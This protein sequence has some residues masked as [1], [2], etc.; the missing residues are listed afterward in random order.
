MDAYRARY[1]GSDE[2]AARSRDLRYSSDFDEEQ[3]LIHNFI[4]TLCIVHERSILDE[5]GG[6]DES[7]Q[8]YEDW[9]LWIRMSRKFKFHHIKKVSCEYS[10]RI[11]GRSLQTGT[12]SDL[13]WLL[14]I[15]YEKNKGFAKDKPHVLEQQRRRLQAERSYQKQVMRIDGL[16]LSYERG[17]YQNEGG[18]RWMSDHGVIVLSAD[19]AHVSGLI[20]FDVSCGAS[21]SYDHF[22]FTVYVV[23]GQKVLRRLRFAMGDQ[24]ERVFISVSLPVKEAL[25]LRLVSEE[26]YVPSMRGMN[27]DIRHLSIRVGKP[28]LWRG[29]LSYWVHQLRRK[30]N[31]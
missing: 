29:W 25:E 28:T 2:H 20:S 4:P 30:I 26:S 13:S 8:V 21:S 11:D 23:R 10:W 5:V 22:P 1:G 7:L 18:W 3:I 14:Q 17:F 15:V 19:V 16:S 24:T 31:L 9:D 27:D 6:F 12:Q